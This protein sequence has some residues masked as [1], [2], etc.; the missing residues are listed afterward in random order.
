MKNEISIRERK[1]ARAKEKRT[2]T[3]LSLTGDHRETFKRLTRKLR[4]CVGG[5]NEAWVEYDEDKD[6][7]LCKVDCNNVDARWG[8][9]CFADGFYYGIF[10]T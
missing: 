10:T 7:T 3:V 2:L 4:A 8:A 5:I 6:Y 9:K 1:A